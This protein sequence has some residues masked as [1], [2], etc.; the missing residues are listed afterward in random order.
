MTTQIVVVT[1]TPTEVIAAFYYPIAEEDRLA[2]AIDS[3]RQPAAPGLLPEEIVDLQQGRLYEVVD[4][5]RI[6]NQPRDAIRTQLAA[7]WTALRQ[8]S[9][10]EYQRKYSVLGS[11][12]DSDT[13]WS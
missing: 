7:R 3:T 5:L 9:I 4:S 1:H 12:L 8:R 6:G 13:G 10:N 11:R 2:T